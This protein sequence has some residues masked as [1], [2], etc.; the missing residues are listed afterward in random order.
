KQPNAEREGALDVTLL[1]D[2]IAVGNPLRR[3]AR[4]QRH[5]DFGYRGAV[6][7]RAHRGQQRQH[8]RRRV[9]LPRIE[10]AAVRQR[11]GEALIVVAHDFEVDDEGRL[12]VLTPVT[13]IAQEFLNTFGHSKHPPKRPSDGTRSKMISDKSAPATLRDGGATRPGNSNR[14]VLPWIGWEGSRPHTWQ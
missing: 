5:L 11:P 14:I 1:L 7:A 10:H 2:R 8:F 4:G 13:A 6:E 3:R 12:D 9:C